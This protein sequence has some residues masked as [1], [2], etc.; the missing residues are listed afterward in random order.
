M[1][2]PSIELA[3]DDGSRLVVQLLSVDESD[4]VP[5]YY[6]VL[7]ILTSTNPKRDAPGSLLGASSSEVVSWQV[8]DGPLD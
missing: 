7:K 2:R 1:A 5:I 6:K 4:A 3:F 8:F